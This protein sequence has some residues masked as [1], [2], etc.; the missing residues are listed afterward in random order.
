[1][2]R[3]RPSARLLFGAILAAA[4]P[5]A[6]PPVAR[7]APTDTAVAPAASPDA[8]KA[9]FLISFV[10]FTDWPA[11]IPPST[12]PYSIGISGNRAIEDELIRLGDRKLVLGHRLRVVRIN[13]PDDLDNLQIAYFDSAA[14]QLD[15]LPAREAL[16]LLRGRP[17]L[18][19]S[20]AEDFIALGGMV[21]IY[22]EEK[23]LH[24]E[25]APEPVRDAGL[26]LSS[27]LLSLARI[28]RAAPPPS[29]PRP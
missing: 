9:A 8:V 26:V 16:P 12:A 28:H 5:L 23:A 11:N 19:V 24:L 10:R 20:D 1:M 27:Y 2:R 17:V 18:T 29:D 4:V 25:I 21:R 7:A 22:R 3:P 13:N 6:S 14:T 15:A